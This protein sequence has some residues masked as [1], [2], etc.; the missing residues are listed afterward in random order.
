[1]VLKC[2]VYI[3]MAL[4]VTVDDWCKW[5]VENLAVWAL[6]PTGKDMTVLVVPFRFGEGFQEVA[7]DPG[8]EACPDVQ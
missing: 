3:R 5:G 8:A 7:K 2:L 1:L 4:V 6:H